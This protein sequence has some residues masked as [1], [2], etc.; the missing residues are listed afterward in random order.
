MIE[1]QQ[2]WATTDVYKHILIAKIKQL[3]NLPKKFK[4]RCQR[5]E[6]FLTNVSCALRQIS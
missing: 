3:L 5:Q 1:K 4:I 6:T 2:Y